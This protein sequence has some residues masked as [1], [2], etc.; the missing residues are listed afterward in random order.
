[1]NK[2]ISILA[3]IVLMAGLAACS[4]DEDEILEVPEP[5][6]VSIEASNGT[7]LSIAQGGSLELK[8][9]VESGTAMRY[10]WKCD[11]KEISSEPTYTF[12]SDE[13]GNHLVELIVYYTPKEELTVTASIQISV[14]K[15]ISSINDL[16]FWT[17]EGENRSVLAI[18]WIKGTEWEE[19]EQKNVTLLGWG[20]RW[21]ESEAPTGE[22]LIR[23]VAK[24]DPRLFVILGQAWG[25]TSIWGLGYDGNNDGV[26][27]V[28][29]AET[30]VEFTEKDFID[31][32]L[33]L[34]EGKGGDTDNL[35]P[36]N[37]EDLWLGGWY[38]NYATY[39]LGDGENVPETMSFEYSQVMASLRSLTNNSWDVWTC[40]SINGGYVNTYPFSQ[41][42][43]GANPN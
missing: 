8:A 32:V 23:A 10:Q 37:S 3:G 34:G 38:A 29:N 9:K 43:V 18:Q 1:M 12:S 35:V 19:P 14:Y 40:S 7:A 25:T 31:G 21:K 16:T 22:Q 2:F 15:H 30:S 26:I 5:P 4:H 20:Y 36:E 39:W 41:W 6:T 13:A 17:G 27:S 28:K 11:G 24:A 42:M 33:V